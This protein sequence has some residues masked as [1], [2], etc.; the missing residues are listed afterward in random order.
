MS[1]PSVDED[2]ELKTFL[3]ILKKVKMHPVFGI[4]PQPISKD[5]KA[6]NSSSA[7]YHIDGEDSA[8]FRPVTDPDAQIPRDEFGRP[9][10][11]DPNDFQDE[12]DEFGRRIDN[13]GNNLAKRISVKIQNLITPSK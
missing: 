9:I 4:K 13:L 8:D 5:E 10:P 6:D 3:K 7:S 12:R 1:F 2:L 11:I